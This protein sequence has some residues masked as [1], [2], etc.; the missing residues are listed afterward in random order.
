MLDADRLILKLIPQAFAIE[1]VPRRALGGVLPASF[2]EDANR[3][4]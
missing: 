1:G 4:P 2:R 3:R